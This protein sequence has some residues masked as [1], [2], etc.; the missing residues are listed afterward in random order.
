[1]TETLYPLNS[2]SPFPSPLQPLAPALCQVQGPSILHTASMSLIL[3]N[4]SYKW[5]TWYLHFLWLF[6]SYSMFLG[7]IHIFTCLHVKGLPYF[8]M[9][10]WGNT[11]F[12]CG[13]SWVIFISL[14]SVF[15]P[16][17]M[18]IRKQIPSSGKTWL[19]F[20]Q[21]GTGIGIDSLHTFCETILWLIVL[22]T[23]ALCYLWIN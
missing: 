12:H 11:S 5:I 9:Q 2:N 21:L 20:F 8:L 4:A 15:L 1:M 13:N 19:R 14:K 18:P 3:L 16:G 23:E 22:G 7:Y 10:Q 17:F 6:I